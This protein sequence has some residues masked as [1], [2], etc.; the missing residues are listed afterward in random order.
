M[1]RLERVCFLLFSA[2]IWI[3][4]YL[5]IGKTLNVGRF[6]FSINS[7][8]SIMVFVSTK[9]LIIFYTELRFILAKMNT[10]MIIILK[11]MQGKVL[12]SI[13]FVMGTFMQ[14][15]YSC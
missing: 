3:L 10:R 9:L 7:I 8:N 4:T 11:L 15:L 12:V 6:Y 14:N 2:L 1:C 5:I 13:F